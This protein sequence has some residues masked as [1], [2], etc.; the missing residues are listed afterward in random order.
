MSGWR[1]QYLASVQEL[2]RNSPA[3][4][5]LVET[6]GNPAAGPDVHANRSCRPGSQLQDRVAAL[7]AERETLV[8]PPN[9]ADQADAAGKDAAGKDTADDPQQARLRLELAETLRSQG[10]LQTRLKAAEDELETLRGRS[11]GD[12]KAIRVLT[13]ER[14]ALVTKVRDRD[15]E[16]RGKSKLVE[17]SLR[18][19]SR[20]FLSWAVGLVG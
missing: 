5:V 12:T 18:L 1:E 13:G 7:L 16:L 17:V 20:S 14:N 15:E 6:C 4:A 10:Q 9:A 8:P 11:R 19:D 3:N 2:Q